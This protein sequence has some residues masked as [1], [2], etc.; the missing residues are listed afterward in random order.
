[1]NINFID[2]DRLLLKEEKYKELMNI[3]SK[4]IIKW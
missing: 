4:C 3:E 1:M 2:I